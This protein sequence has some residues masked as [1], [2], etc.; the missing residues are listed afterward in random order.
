MNTLTNIN[1]LMLEENI[2]KLFKSKKI[3]YFKTLDSTQSYASEIVSKNKPKEKTAILTFDQGNGIGQLGAKWYSEPSKN[4]A[5]SLILFPDF[6]RLEDQ[7]LLSQAAALAV[8]E[9]I[10]NYVKSDVLI[11]W[12]ND[13]LVNRKKIAGILINNSIQGTKITSC[14]IGI[15]INVNQTKFRS[16]LPFAVSIK[17][18]SNVE[19]DL[20]EIVSE[21]LENFD[22]Y[23]NLLESGMKQMIKNRYLDFLYGYQEQLIYELQNGTM[24]TGEIIGVREDGRLRLRT[25]QGEKIYDIREIKFRL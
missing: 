6:V 18:E 3:I 8:R 5:L 25:N 12:P 11:K 16:D 22:K 15:G 23:Y 1:I 20:F 2:L 13:I 10:Q 17:S 7:F 19:N 24:L 9:T 21:L 4:I 14:I